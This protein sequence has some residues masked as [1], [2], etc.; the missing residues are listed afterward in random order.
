MIPIRSGLLQVAS[1]ALL[2]L[3]L[4]AQTPTTLTLDQAIVLGRERGVTA[5]LATLNVRIADARVGQRRAD[6]LPSVTLGA[7]AIRQTL[8]LDEV[9]IAFASGVT[10]PF[11][12]WR[13]QASARE[14]LF[15]ASALARLHAARD[16]A[17]VSG[18]DARAVGELTAA[19]AGLTYLRARTVSTALSAR[20]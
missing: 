3:Q 17:L 11:T 8:N 2:P 1:A 19:T 20:R 9:G 16:S 6:L 10:D 7:G 13:F 15:D 14:T 4:L 18:A 5:A 12:V